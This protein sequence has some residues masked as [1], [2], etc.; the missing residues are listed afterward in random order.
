MTPLIPSP[1]D[2]VREYDS[3][4]WA[5][6][7]R[8][9]EYEGI[10]RK[11]TQEETDWLTNV[12]FWR[13]YPEYA[14]Q[15]LA[16]GDA[17]AIATWLRLREMVRQALLQTHPPPWTRSSP[18]WPLGR[19]PAT[20]FKAG[21]LFGAK[22]PWKGTTTRHHC[23]I[24]LGA[25][26]GTPMLA[27]EAGVSLGETGW[28]APAKAVLLQ[29]D[30][31]L[32]V[33]LGGS[34]AGSAAP[35]GTRV[36]AGQQV[37]KVGAYPNGSTMLHFQLYDGTLTAAQVEARK[38]WAWDAPRPDH[39]LDPLDYLRTAAARTQLPAGEVQGAFLG[40]GES[41]N[42]EEGEATEGTSGSPPASPAPPTD[43][44]ASPRPGWTT[45]AAGGALILSFL[46]RRR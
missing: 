22:R 37:A 44:V 20:N 26:L 36:A 8:P 33:L 41:P 13:S 21:S 43:P 16:P 31:G 30:S 4:A 32:T 11:A 10:A 9:A 14:G 15:K 46:F 6:H 19:T 40:D 23:G 17:P 27:P 39:L 28:D 45:L 34:A 18:V 1:A 38:S 42:I 7:E 29:L 35:K 12:A 24:D 2:L 5:V 25:P 3:A